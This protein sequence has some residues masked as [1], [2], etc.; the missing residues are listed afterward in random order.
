MEVVLSTMINLTPEERN[1]AVEK[2]R[3]AYKLKQE[4]TAAEGGKK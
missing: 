1:E 2:L 4:Q 3:L